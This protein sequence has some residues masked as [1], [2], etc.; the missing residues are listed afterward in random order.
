MIPESGVEY[1]I[2]FAE[3][4]CNIIP[5]GA[6]FTV[7]EGDT[8]TWR[9]ASDDFKLDIF[10]VGD[11]IDE[12]GIARR[13]MREKRVVTE[14][15]PRALYGI[16]LK[17]VA[18]PLV[19]EEGDVQRVFSIALPRLHPVVSAFKDF[20]PI[21]SGM[22]PEG[23]V[24]A[25]S[26]LNKIEKKQASEKFDVPSMKEGAGFGEDSIISKVIEAKKPMFEEE[27]DIAKYGVPVSISSAPLFDEDTGEVVATLGLITPR[28][29]AAHLQDIANSLSEGIT[30]ISSAIEELAASASEIHTNEQKLNGEITEV[31]NLSEQINEV[32]SFIKEIADETKMLGL[33]AAIEAARAGEVGRGFG[34]V[35]EE[36]RKLSEQS[37]STVPKIK[38]LTDTI[39]S[40]VGRASEMSKNSLNSSQEQAAA[41]Q[42]ITASIEE[43]TSMAE[44]LNTIARKL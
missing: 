38:E 26:D 8:I 31:T 35:A 7:I 40:N 18:I 13:A 33:N 30:G 25:V 10:N 12:N 9:Q 28:E 4:E 27:Q 14:N 24:I 19:N 29:A 41:T 15:V 1:L 39:K 6:I 34:V 42:E 20:A 37:K 43:I 44:T 32:S 2:T 36:I 3:L 22:F 17:T 21:I 5:G 23:S 16:R 11:K